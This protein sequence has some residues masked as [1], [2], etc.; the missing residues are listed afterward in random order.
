MVYVRR[1]WGYADG[2]EINLK[3][4]DVEDEWQTTLPPDLV[5]GWY[6]TVLYAEASTGKIGVWHGILYV[7]N[8]ISH[9]HIK[10]EKFTWWF[11][12][13]TNL[14][15]ILRQTDRFGYELLNQK[16]IEFETRPPRCELILQ[17]ECEY[18]GS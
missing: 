5:D 6:A 14:K 7:A 4:T 13:P 17:E 2:I 12:P 9:L 3:K 16:E 8:G 15:L 10:E 11:L 18:H 1:V